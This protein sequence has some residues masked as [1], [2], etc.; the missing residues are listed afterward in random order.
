MP[1]FQEEASAE[2]LEREMG[3]LEAPLPRLTSPPPVN[4]NPLADGAKHEVVVVGV[5]PPPHSPKTFVCPVSAEYS[6]SDKCCC[7]TS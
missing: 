7:R 2:M 3:I 1:V 5:S 6:K 4:A